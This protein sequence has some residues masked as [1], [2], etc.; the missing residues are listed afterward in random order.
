MQ[1]LVLIAFIAIVASFLAPSICYADASV[2]HSL[3]EAREHLLKERENLLADRAAINSKLNNLVSSRLQIDKA[4]NGN[5]GNR[6][7]MTDARANLIAQIYKMQNYLDH[8][9]RDLM[10]ND[11]D[12]GVVES[13][14]RRF[15]CMNI[16]SQ[17]Y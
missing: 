8:T 1:K 6:Q 14:I 17:T 13:E 7:A 2:P 10:N 3:T 15:A 9:E 11:K 4:L 16:G 12:L 5:P